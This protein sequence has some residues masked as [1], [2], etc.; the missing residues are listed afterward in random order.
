MSRSALALQSDGTQGIQHIEWQLK[1]HSRA[2]E[3]RTL[4][5]QGV[6]SDANLDLICSLCAHAVRCLPQLASTPEMACLPV[7]LPW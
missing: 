7:A 3:I 6:H 4:R 5:H 1:V 2:L